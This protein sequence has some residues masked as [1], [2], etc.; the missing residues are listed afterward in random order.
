MLA[1]LGAFG[2]FFTLLTAAPGGTEGPMA[3]LLALAGAL[4]ALTGSAVVVRSRAELG[5]AGA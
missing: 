1:N 3:L 2:L 5:A 4:V